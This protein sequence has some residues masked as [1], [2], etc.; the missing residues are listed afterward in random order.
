[1]RL[2]DGNGDG[3]Y[4]TADKRFIGDYVPKWSWNLRNDFKIYKDFD[5]SFTLVC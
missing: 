5:L 1:M 3:K 2:V 4:T